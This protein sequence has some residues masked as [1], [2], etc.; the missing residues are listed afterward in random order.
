MDNMGMDVTDERTRRGFIVGGVV[1]AGALSLLGVD[2]A[3]AVTTDS[4]SFEDVALLIGPDG[5]RPAPGSEF[6]EDK[7]AYHYLYVGTANGGRYVI[8]D[9]SDSWALLDV[10]AGAVS[11][12]AMDLSAT[13]PTLG[14]VRHHDGSDGNPAGLYEGKDTTGD[15]NADTW[16]EVAPTDD[17]DTQL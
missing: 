6:F 10:K 1:G 2:P 13:D 11:G 9:D 4:D 14:T 3:E 16:A 17:T 12:K 8:D 5:E 15:G 7:A